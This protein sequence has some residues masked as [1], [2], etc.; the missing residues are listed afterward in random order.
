L[1]RRPYV[2]RSLGCLE[3]CRAV[4][5]S[6]TCC[7][8]HRCL[9]STRMAR[10]CIIRPCTISVPCRYSCKA[11]SGQRRC[12]SVQWR[13]YSSILEDN[14]IIASLLAQRTRIHIVAFRTSNTEADLFG[15]ALDAHQRSSSPL[16]QESI[17]RLALQPAI[18]AIYNCSENTI[19]K[20]GT[21]SHV[22]ASSWVQSKIDWVSR[23]LSR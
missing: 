11:R 5:T 7:I 18:T 12:A 4:L 16:T 8:E 21:S 2:N 3:S 19:H 13:S 15:K 6:I 17:I 14:F 1:K 9:R 20:C 10:K 23:L 22:P